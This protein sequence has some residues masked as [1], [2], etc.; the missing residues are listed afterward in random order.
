[1]PIIGHGVDIVE[2][3]RI[4]RMLDEHADRFLERCFTERERA[5]ATGAKRT[6]EHLAGR[7]A[8]KEAALKAIGTGWRHGIAWTDVEVVLEATGAPRLEVTGRVAEIAAELGIGAWHV[9]ISHTQTHA[10]ASVI[11]ESR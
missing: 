5:Y 6:G 3:A 1:M 4:G 9:S 8:A 7:F 2:V 11:A 10:I